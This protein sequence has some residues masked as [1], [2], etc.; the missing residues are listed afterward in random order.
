MAGRAFPSAG[1]FFSP[2]FFFFPSSL[3]TILKIYLGAVKWP[4]GGKRTEKNTFIY[5]Y[6]TFFFFKA[7]VGRFFL[8]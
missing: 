6:I 4:T 1:H 7:S 8:L 3:F 5:L 2:F